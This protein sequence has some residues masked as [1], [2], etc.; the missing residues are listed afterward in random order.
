MSAENKAHPTG[1]HAQGATDASIKFRMRP[2]RSAC[3]ISLPLK[4]RRLRNTGGAALQRAEYVRARGSS[5]ALVEKQSRAAL[6]CKLHRSTMRSGRTTVSYLPSKLRRIA[7]RPAQPAASESAQACKSSLLQARA[8]SDS[9]SLSSRLPF[10]LTC[11]F[12]LLASFSSR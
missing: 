5:R 9:V 8:D 4:L 2:Y 10:Y 6:E 7:F 1:M 3:R 11:K 12:K